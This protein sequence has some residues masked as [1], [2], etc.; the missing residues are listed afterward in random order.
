MSGAK[1]NDLH[2]VR[3]LISLL[4]FLASLKLSDI[5]EYD[6]VQLLVIIVF[7]NKAVIY[8]L[9]LVNNSCETVVCAHG[10]L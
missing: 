4:S 7:V 2:M 6:S 1:C 3:L 5:K 8:Y 10:K 9:W